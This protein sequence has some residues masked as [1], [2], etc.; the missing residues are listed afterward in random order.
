MILIDFKFQSE[1]QCIS[2]YI[3]QDCQVTARSV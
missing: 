1:T 3:S 2:K